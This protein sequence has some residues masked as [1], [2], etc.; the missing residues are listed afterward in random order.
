MPRL[1]CQ[2]T[3]LFFFYSLFTCAAAA[4]LRCL[5]DASVL[6]AAYS[7]RGRLLGLERWRCLPLCAALELS[8]NLA[9]LLR[10]VALCLS[11]QAK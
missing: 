2:G 1:E 8:R 7:L 4:A 10:E 3:A 11:Q 6:A 5:K 9:S